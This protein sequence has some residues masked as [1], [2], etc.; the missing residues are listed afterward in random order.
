MIEL[1]K[2]KV[3]AGRVEALL[4]RLSSKNLIVIKGSRGYVMCGYLNQSAAQAFGDAAVK[5]KGVSTI[6][7]A[8]KA[9]VFSCTSAARRLGIRPGQAVKDALAAIA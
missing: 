5:I 6:E 3:G 2:I 4:L 9:K 7:E 1:K 8:V